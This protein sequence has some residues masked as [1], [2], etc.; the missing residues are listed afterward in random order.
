MLQ[1]GGLIGLFTDLGK[2]YFLGLWQSGG[3]IAALLFVMIVSEKGNLRM[4]EI[5]NL[6]RKYNLFLF[7]LWTLVFILNH[8]SP[9]SANSTIDEASEKIKIIQENYRKKI[10]PLYVI[11]NSS[12]TKEE[13]VQKFLEGISQ[14][15]SDLFACSKEEYLEIFLPNS[16]DEKTLTSQMEPEKAWEITQLRRDPALQELTKILSNKDVKVTNISW[17]RQNRKLNSLN[18]HQIGSVEMKVDGKDFSTE[19]IKLVIENNNQFKV[20]V[21]AK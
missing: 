17:K 15:K 9:K 4:K 6:L 7:I 3:T 16:V 13:A 5:Y 10:Q 8:C 19:S 21:Y 14:G 18:S 11:E 12:L 2:K 1:T 20:C